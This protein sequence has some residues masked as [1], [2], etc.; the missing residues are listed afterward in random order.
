MPVTAFLKS[1]LEQFSSLAGVV[2][3]NNG[4]QRVDCTDS[5]IKS[6]SKHQSNMKVSVKGKYKA[7][8]VQEFWL[9]L[10]NHD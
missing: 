8:A 5:E 6:G 4:G 10:C 2:E 3:S 1:P 9:H 7:V